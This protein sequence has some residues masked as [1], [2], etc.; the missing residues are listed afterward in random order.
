MSKTVVIGAGGGGYTNSTST[1]GQGGAC[2][3]GS[4]HSV[5]V[6][7]YGIYLSG[8][9]GKAYGSA[10]GQASKGKAVGIGSNG[11]VSVIGHCGGVSGARDVNIVLIE[12]VI[13]S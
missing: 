5:G 7:Y 13:D 12:A 8:G 2:G 10:V 11:M 9:G 3:G 1:P 4:V 6:G